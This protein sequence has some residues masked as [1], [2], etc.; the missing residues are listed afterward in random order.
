MNAKQQK[1]VL[2]A[3]KRAA[4]RYA[5]LHDIPQAKCP[6][7]VVNRAVLAQVIAEEF[8]RVVAAAGDARGAARAGRGEP[9]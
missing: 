8:A 7:S 2:A 1:R 5:E 6:C 3:A 4:K 9:K